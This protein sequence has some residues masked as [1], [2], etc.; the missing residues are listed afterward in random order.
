MNLVRS[1]EHFLNSHTVLSPLSCE[2]FNLLIAA[3][4]PFSAVYL[5]I[6]FAFRAIVRR[7][8]MLADSPAS[9]GVGRLLLVAGFKSCKML[10]FDWSCKVALTRAQNGS[11]IA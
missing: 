9:L 3:A 11:Y 1:P 10:I 8:V 7:T 2:A 5:P 4:L 6:V